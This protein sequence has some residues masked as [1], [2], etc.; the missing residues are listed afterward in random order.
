MRVYISTDME[1]TA[2]VVNWDQV[3]PGKPE[4]E[5]TR[6][7]QIAEVNAAI[8]G[9]LEAGAERVFV[10][11]LH[12]S[13]HN[14]PAEH[15]HPEGEFYMGKHP[16]YTRFP[17]IEEGFDLMLC[18]GYHAMANVPEAILSHTM[19]G[20]YMYIALNGKEIGELAMDALWAGL[21][22][23]GV[24]MVSGGSAVCAEAKNLLGPDVQTAEVK[25]GMSRFGGVFMSPEKARVLIRE[26]A[27]AAVRK[28]RQNKP[29]PLKLDPPYTLEMELESQELT[30]KKLSLIAEAERTG[31]RSVALTGDDLN[32]LMFDILV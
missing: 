22:D 6:L 12:Y 21:H 31:T 4:Y 2:G 3:T 8:D 28:A 9:A 32:R 17:C 18:I 19:S 25:R 14:F 16:P 10:A 29:S 20:V 15:L 5:R 11:D 24:G 23:V 13:G 27:A 30:E 26:S 7:L 1:G